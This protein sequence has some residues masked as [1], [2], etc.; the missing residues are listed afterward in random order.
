MPSHFTMTDL[1][2]QSHQVQ[3]YVVTALLL[4]I[5]TVAVALRLAA[6][7]VSS[8]QFWWDDYTI[9]VALVLPFL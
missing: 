5:A 8:A 3:I 9:I 7:R 4:V 1:Y 6:R 2:Y